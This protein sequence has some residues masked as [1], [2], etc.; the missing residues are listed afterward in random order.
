MVI[1][2]IT[3]AGILVDLFNLGEELRM[4]ST[5]IRSFRIMRMLKLIR[6]NIHM[7]LVLDT[8]FNIL[9]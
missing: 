5:I 1:V 6:S 3:D 4:I 7:R 8:C 9:P 2:I